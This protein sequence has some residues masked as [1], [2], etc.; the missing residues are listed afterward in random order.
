MQCVIF[1]VGNFRLDWNLCYT[2]YERHIC[3]GYYC[4]LRSIFRLVVPFSLNDLCNI[5]LFCVL[6]TLVL[7]SVVYF[8]FLWPLFPIHTNSSMLLQLPNL[9]F[10]PTSLVLSLDYIQFSQQSG[11][12]PTDKTSGHATTS[13]SRMWHL[14]PPSSRMHSY[15]LFVCVFIRLVFMHGSAF[16]IVCCGVLIAR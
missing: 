12:P 8:V 15:A 11:C 9:I 2:V 10:T 7:T 3:M 4:L 13:I 14:F 6:L 16:I 1:I 5:C